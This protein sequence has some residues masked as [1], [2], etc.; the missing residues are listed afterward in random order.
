MTN[1]K[2]PH[3]GT[4]TGATMVSTFLGLVRGLV[5]TPSPVTKI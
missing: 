1:M 5:K 4:I 2:A 3:P